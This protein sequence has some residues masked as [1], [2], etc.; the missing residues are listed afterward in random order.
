ML[1]DSSDLN[2]KPAQLNHEALA[3]HHLYK[4]PATGHAPHPGKNAGVPW[5][6]GASIAYAVAI[7]FLAQIAASAV[8]ILYP[9][10]HGWN[11]TYANNWLDHSVVAQFWFI[12][13]AEI[14]TFGGI[15]WF[16]RHRGSSL[17]A[18][19]WRRPH[20]KDPVYAL[21]GF[22][23]YFIGYSVL[24]GIATAVFTSINVDQKQDLGFT[25]AAGGLNLF[26]TFLSLVVLPP[27]VEETVFRGF[28]FTGLRGKLHPVWAAI[29]TSLLFASAHLQFGNGKP[30]LWVA[31]ID[32]F[33]LSLVMCYMRQ[34]SG[35]LWPGIFLH[36]LKNMIAFISLFL[37]ASH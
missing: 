12:L 34:K 33:T 19:G 35:S 31:G 30:L 16:V 26:L 6:I 18:I 28:V 22:L 10:L 1:K 3:E 21:A 17:R 23:V 24:L 29:L 15:W 25:D 11:H 4:H 7:Y 5:G 8:V 36:A 27:L 32:T 2:P 20:L 13:V 9:R 37:V 14:L